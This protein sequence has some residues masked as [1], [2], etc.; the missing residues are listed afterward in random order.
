MRVIRRKKDYELTD[1]QKS[2]RG[3]KRREYEIDAQIL[4]ALDK[5]DELIAAG[6]D[7]LKNLLTHPAGLMGKGSRERLFATD[8]EERDYITNRYNEFETIFD[9]DAWASEL[10]A[11]INNELSNGRGAGSERFDRVS[12]IKNEALERIRGDRGNAAVKFARADAL[13]EFKRM[14]LEKDM[15]DIG[16]LYE[17]TEDEIIQEHEANVRQVVRDINADRKALGLPIVKLVE[18]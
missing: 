8:K 16:V 17:L 18:V 4:V 10:D 15:L 6:F 11:D 1:E 7:P 3:R 9:A 12:S 5:K 14:N 2:I 13:K